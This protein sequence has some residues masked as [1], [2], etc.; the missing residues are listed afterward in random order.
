MHVLRCQIDVSG[1]EGGVC[2]V[3]ERT[4]MGG[5]GSYQQKHG[6]GQSS[7]GERMCRLTAHFSKA[8]WKCWSSS[9]DPDS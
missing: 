5:V 2:G 8:I 9:V 4:G 6:S 3:V 7:L 1:G